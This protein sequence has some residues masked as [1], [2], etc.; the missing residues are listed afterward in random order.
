VAES[1]WIALLDELDEEAWHSGAEPEVSDRFGEDPVA[2][3]EE[4]TG[5]PVLLRGADA[6]AF[7]VDGEEVAP[8]LP[9]MEAALDPRTEAQLRSQRAREVF[10]AQHEAGPWMDDYWDL[11]EEGYTWR[12][13]VYML[14]EAQPPDRRRPRYQNE[15]ATQVLGLT[16][17]RVVSQWKAENPAMAARIARLTVS[18]LAKARSRI[19]AA[20][21][22]SASDPNP[23][24]HSDRKM[25]LQMT[26]DYVDTQNVQVGP[27]Q[28]LSRMSTE[29]LAAMAQLPETVADGNGGD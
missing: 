19:I 15:L 18:A 12:Q 16:T 23:R 17:D 22:E 4:S 9:G 26:G 29:D 27:I 25:A 7:V 21:I 14:W 11:L 13:A 24:S 5:Y 8:P 28:D 3:S 6:E 2:G 1:D 10:E 20:L